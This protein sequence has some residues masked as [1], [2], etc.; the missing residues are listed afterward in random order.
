[1]AKS[2]SKRQDLP[3]W[4]VLLAIICFAFPLALYP[5]ARGESP[6]AQ[7][8]YVAAWPGDELVR[9][10][11]S[12]SSGEA[13]AIYAA[14]AVSGIC[15]SADGGKTWARPNMH[16]PYS[17]SGVVRII[18]LTV[19]PCDPHVAYAV[20]AS[21]SSNPRPMLYWTE[22]E[23]LSWRARGGLGPKRVKATA[24]APTGDAL[25]IAAA[26][27][28][29]RGFVS[30]DGQKR[31]IQGQDDLQ[32]AYVAPLDA[33]FQVS[34]IAVGAPSAFGANHLTSKSS[35]RQDVD[36][37]WPIYIGTHDDGLRI[38]VD[39]RSGDPPLFPVHDDPVS[40]YVREQAS[41]H[42]LCFWPD[43][44]QV[45]YV[46]TD[47]GIYVSQDGGVSW[48]HTAYALYS[49]QVR[50]LLIDTVGDTL[51][52]GLAGDGVYYSED[53]GVTW[54]PL[55][56]GLG[57]LSVYSLALVTSDTRSL[58][59]G[60]NNGLWRFDLPEIEAASGAFRV[61]LGSIDVG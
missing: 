11:A 21:S 47:D 31:F 36:A 30:Q 58:L 24:F 44:P 2:P 39:D 54:L 1:M 33:R 19:N 3:V 45:V 15:A 60:T 59:A 10:L 56:R 22:N 37:S 6:S 41:I 28:L 18:H 40:Q 55:G 12:G 38:I 27:A 49:L 61:N 16:V 4:Q 8:E 5:A 57:H 25:Y 14:G 51:Y 13:R 32:K 50:S 23:G 20:L 17:R 26:G 9:H 34:T 43:A 42:A 7:W 53:R 35:Q 29:L 46:G 52:A 48:L